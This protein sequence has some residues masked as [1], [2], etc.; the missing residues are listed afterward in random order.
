MGVPWRVSSEL[1]QENRL[2]ALFLSSE[3][4]ASDVI[5]DA[6]RVDEVFKAAY[7]EFEDRKS[8]VF[9]SSSVDGGPFRTSSIYSA[10]GK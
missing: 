3:V 8:D 9:G 4:G 5:D 7:S 1:N 10:S 6:G 2:L